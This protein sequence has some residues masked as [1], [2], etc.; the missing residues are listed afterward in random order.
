MT[1]PRPVADPRLLGRWDS[2]DYGAME[3]VSVWFRVDGTGEYRWE[4]ASGGMEVIRFGWECPEPGVLRVE[5]RYLT[6]GAWSR[7][8][9][10]FARVDEEGPTEG[11]LATAYRLQGADELLLEQALAFCCHFVRAQADSASAS[12]HTP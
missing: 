8:T 4:N 7:G 1:P 6:S 5:E 3:S 10:G 11:E 2:L 12:R 9:D